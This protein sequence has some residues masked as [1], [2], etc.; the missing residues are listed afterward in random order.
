MAKKNK[1]A[2]NRLLEMTIH[3]YM[4][5]DKQADERIHEAWKAG[6]I[7]GISIP[8]FI[9]LIIKIIQSIIF[10]ISMKYWP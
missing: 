7:L 8:I 9:F 5:L 4:M 3:H 10:A 6:L 2:E 1:E